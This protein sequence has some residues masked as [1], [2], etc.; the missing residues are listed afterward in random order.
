[1][2]LSIVKRVRKDKLRPVRSL[3]ACAGEKN[4]SM[5]VTGIERNVV[6]GGGGER[7]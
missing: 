7:R 5:L 6:P 4:V 2:A 3:N 1:M